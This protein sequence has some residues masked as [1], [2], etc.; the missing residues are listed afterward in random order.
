MAEGLYRIKSRPYRSPCDECQ[1]VISDFKNKVMRLISSCS[2]LILILLLNMYDYNLHEG[3]DDLLERNEFQ[4][5]IVREIRIGCV[6]CAKR[7]SNG[8]TND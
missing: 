1:C 3:L 7:E 5:L 2:D 4:P 8:S 6:V